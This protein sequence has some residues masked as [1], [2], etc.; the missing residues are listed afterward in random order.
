[1]VT[2]E[3]CQMNSIRYLC[4]YFYYGAVIDCFI[5]FHVYHESQFFLAQRVPLV[6]QK[7]P[8]LP[9]HMTSLFFSG[10]CVARS[11]VFCVVF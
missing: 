11:F 7:M 6:E 2:P 5:K 8:T 1:M 10:V 4:Y 3:T 9:E